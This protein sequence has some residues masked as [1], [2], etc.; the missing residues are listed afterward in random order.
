MKSATSFTMR[1]LNRRTADVLAAVRKYGVV[2]LCSRSGEVFT[3]APKAKAPPSRSKKAV[4]IGAEF[5]AEMQER[6]ERMSAVGY[7]PPS[8]ADFDQERFNRIIAGE[9]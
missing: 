7:T 6:R 2:E 1:D 5:E 8:A 3:L 4:D 9:E